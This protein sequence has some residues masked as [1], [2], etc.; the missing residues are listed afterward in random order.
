MSIDGVGIG[1]KVKIFDFLYDLSFYP[2]MV[3]STYTRDFFTTYNYTA[4][5]TFIYKTS[6]YKT[7]DYKTSHITCIQQNV[8]SLPFFTLKIKDT[9]R[10]KSEKELVV[11]LTALQVPCKR[12]SV[13]GHPALFMQNVQQVLE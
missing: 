10:P 2:A 13:T 1:E 8:I 4:H 3:F 7:S 12:F 6:I 9:P 5:Q 11:L